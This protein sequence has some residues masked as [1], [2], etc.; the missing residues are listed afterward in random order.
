MGNNESIEFR[1]K[2]ATDMFRIA[3]MR[4]L[5][6]DYSIDS[7]ILDYNGCKFPLDIEEADYDIES[8]KCSDIMV[9]KLSC[10][11]PDVEDRCRPYNHINTDNFSIIDVLE[12]AKVE[13]VSIYIHYND[14]DDEDI[15]LGL[16]GNCTY[17]M[18][19]ANI[20]IDDRRITCDIYDTEIDVD[21]NKEFPVNNIFYMN[22]EKSYSFTLLD[23][24]SI[25]PNMEKL[26]IFDIRQIINKGKYIKITSYDN[27]NITIVIYRKQ[28]VPNDL[29]LY[30]KT[31]LPT[32]YTTHKLIR[33]VV[34]QN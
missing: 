31:Q 7:V 30:V 10:P 29:L 17:V 16:S 1:G 9:F 32:G 15:K 33:T 21:K 23:Q 12:Y 22:E 25:N 18:V 14:S 6:I 26:I 8:D 24:I 19:S 20:F 2:I 13:S 27:D 28:N 34:E 11:V 4:G 5:N 3:N